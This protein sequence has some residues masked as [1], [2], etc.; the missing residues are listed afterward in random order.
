MS[1]QRDRVT[2]V[3]ADGVRGQASLQGQMAFVVGQNRADLA[4]QRGS[5][6]VEVDPA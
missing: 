5:D 1:E 6:P 3:G 4:R 2:D